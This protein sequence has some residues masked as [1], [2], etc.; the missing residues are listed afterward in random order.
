MVAVL[1]GCASTSS[2]SR[3]PVAGQTEGSPAASPSVTAGRSR[4]VVTRRASRCTRHQL[5]VSFGPVGAASGV[6]SA[7]VR[8]TNVSARPCRLA[9]YLTVQRLT[10]FGSPVATRVVH[11]GSSTGV[12]PDPGTH[13]FTV[14]PGASASALLGW[15]DNPGTSVSGRPA[16]PCRASNLL[17]VRLPDRNRG[18]IIATGKPSGPLA[19]NRINA[20]GG[21]LTLTALQDRPSPRR[22]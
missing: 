8:L 10:S 14:R 17:R 11:A 21:R 15:G 1:T 12:F 6:E 2:A 16:K 4:P 19:A 18:V 20:C 9:G 22:M 5:A 7:R 3:V 13:R